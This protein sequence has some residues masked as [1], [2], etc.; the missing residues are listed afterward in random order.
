MNEMARRGDKVSFKT[1]FWVE[2]HSLRSVTLWCA[3]PKAPLWGGRA[4]VHRRPMS[5][6]YFHLFISSR[7]HVRWYRCQ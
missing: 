1:K 4:N 2:V 7:A 5:L 3:Q 6:L